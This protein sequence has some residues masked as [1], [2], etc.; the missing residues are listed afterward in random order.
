MDENPSPRSEKTSSEKTSKSNKPSPIP[1]SHYNPNAKPPT[2]KKRT[3]E[4][5]TRTIARNAERIVD[6][7]MGETDIGELSQHLK[8][9]PNLLPLPHHQRPNS[10]H[11]SHLAPKIK[12]L[13]LK[14]PRR[15]SRKITQE[16]RELIS[17][18]RDKTPLIVVSMIESSFS[19][20]ISTNTVYVVWRETRKPEST[21]EEPG[22]EV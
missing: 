7:L 22:Q 11:P 14:P 12:P 10:S 13:A 8:R 16:M 4:D 5:I 17:L 15:R 3:R 1:G 19:V 9:R 20:T 2:P 18:N 21:P 6:L